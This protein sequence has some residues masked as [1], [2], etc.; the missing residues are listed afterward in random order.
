MLVHVL[1]VSHSIVSSRRR[2]DIYGGGLFVEGIVKGASSSRGLGIGRR[3]V[4]SVT[5]GRRWSQLVKEIR[6]PERRHR[7]STIAMCQAVRSAFQ[8]VGKSSR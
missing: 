1:F 8:K 3:D 6:K 7:D 2:V 4:E 5:V